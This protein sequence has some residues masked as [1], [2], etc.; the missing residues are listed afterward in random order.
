MTIEVTSVDHNLQMYKNSQG[1]CDFIRDEDMFYPDLEKNSNF[2]AK[3]TCPIPKG[4]YT[5]KSYKIPIE[6]VP[7]APYGKYTMKV[8]FT[9]DGRN[10]AGYTLRTN[11]KP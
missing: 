2:P 9:L 6:K 4:E 10:I 5:V 7:P 3:G 11:L 1:V 8:T